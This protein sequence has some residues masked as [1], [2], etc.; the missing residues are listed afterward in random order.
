[1]IV[2]DDSRVQQILS[3]A[4]DPEGYEIKLA[5]N[6]R[7]ALDILQGWLPDLIILDLVMP[8]MDGWS[9]RAQQLA[10]PRAAA[11][12][13]LIITG[14]DP[15]ADKVEQLQATATLA[16]PFSVKTVRA[17]VQSLTM[18]PPFPPSAN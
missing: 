18:A 15:L 3:L 6:G 13:I 16:K 14:L 7:E 1:L 8:E 10:Q 5:G 12:P 17:L 11:I 4:L 2:E 9:F